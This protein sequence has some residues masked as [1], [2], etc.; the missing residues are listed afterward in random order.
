GDGVVT[1]QQGA[2]EVRRHQFHALLA[3]HPSQR[4]VSGQ[5]RIASGHGATSSSRPPSQE[6]SAAGTYTDPS[7]CWW[8][9]S[10]HAI[11]RATAHRV[12]FSVAT[13]SFPRSPFAR[14]FSRRAWK[15]VQFDVLVSSRY[16]A[17]D[18]NHASMS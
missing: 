6:R 9:S 3:A 18:G 5:K 13:G 2:V 17:C 14:M 4:R 1:A 8:W 7:G 12:P 11:V 10:R 15:V 16:A